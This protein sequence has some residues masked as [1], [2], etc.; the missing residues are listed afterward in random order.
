MLRAC[1]WFGFVVN[2]ERMTQ[3]SSATVARFGSSS[4]ISMPALPCFANENFVGISPAVVRSVRRSAVAG[5]WPAYFMSA[6]FGSHRSTCDGPPVMN[7]RITCFAFGAKCGPTTCVP[8]ASASS[9]SRS[10]RPS[11]PMPPH[12]HF[13]ASRRENLSMAKRS[14]RWSRA[15]PARNSRSVG[16]ARDTPRRA[17]LRLDVAFLENTFR[18]SD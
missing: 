13:S 17:R 18:Y 14:P 11:M 7:S 9:A 6:G 5:R 16:G 4:L 2:I 12:M 1:S 3:S 15:A 10:A 8:A